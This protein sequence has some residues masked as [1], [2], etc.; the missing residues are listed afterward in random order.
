MEKFSGQLEELSRHIKRTDQKLASVPDL[1]ESR[2]L[3][4]SA[5]QDALKSYMSNAGTEEKIRAAV[6]KS[7][8]GAIEDR[9]SVIIDRAIKEAFSE[10]FE[11]VGQKYM[12]T[13]LV[14]RIS[15]SDDF[16]SM[17]DQKFRAILEYL[18]EDVL[19]KQIKKMMGP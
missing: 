13:N 8:Q 18:R 9:V 6:E 7:F 19:P 5:I 1:D 11:K 16:K 14:E 10:Q 12:D 3:V 4:D 2:A 15:G 17:I